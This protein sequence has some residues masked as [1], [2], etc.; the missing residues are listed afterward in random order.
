MQRSLLLLAALAGFGATSAGAQAIPFSQHGTVFQRVAVTDILITYNRPTARGRQLFPGVVNWG[1]IWNPGADSAPRVMF[2]KDVKLAGPSIKAGEY[3][4]WV[5]PAEVGPWTF[6]LNKEAHVYHD[7]YPG[8]QHDL[9]RFPVTPTRGEH[10]EAL[11]YYFP[12][13][14]RDKAVLRLHWGTVVIALVIE[15]GWNAQ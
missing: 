15:T 10:M 3:S 9:I 7:P 5:I 12:E 2:S 1:R 11:A 14:R 13:V 8:E 6:I 4:L